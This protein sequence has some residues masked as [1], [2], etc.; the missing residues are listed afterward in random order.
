MCLPSRVASPP[1]PVVATRRRRNPARIGLPARR[2][3]SPR[4][5]RSRS[6]SVRTR[7]PDGSMPPARRR[8]GPAFTRRRQSPP[9]WEV[10]PPSPLTTSPVL[11][12]SLRSTA[13]QADPVKTGIPGF[14]NWTATR[15]CVCRQCGRCLP[16]AP[17]TRPRL[18]RIC[19]TRF[20]GA[21]LLAPTLRG[22]LGGKSGKFSRPALRLP[23]AD[24]GYGSPIRAC[25]LWTYR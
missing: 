17:M 3:N 7:R 25:Q 20:P 14:S 6:P 22:R 1:S 10:Q 16:Q 4:S 8:D 2:P 19:R 9:I 23:D 24:Q 13:L 15:H 21:A 5:R 12:A 18:R 11:G